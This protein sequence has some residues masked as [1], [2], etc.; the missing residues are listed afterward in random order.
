MIGRP[1]SAE[2]LTFSFD[3]V[4]PYAWLASREVQAAADRCGVPLVW[5]PVLLGGL[6][7][8]IGTPDQPATTWSDA[9]RRQDGLDLFRRAEL[10]G[11]ALQ[12]HPQHPRRSVSAMRL[13]VAA[14]DPVRPALAKDLFET[15]WVRNRDI[16]DRA[17]LAPVARAHGLDLAVIDQ[18][19][20]KA[21]LW[22]TTAQA[23]AEGAFG[24]PTYTWQGRIWW[25][26][27]RL[28]LVE[29]ALGHARA[30]AAP[31]RRGRPTLRWFHDFASPFSYLASTQIARLA[32]EHGAE[33][34]RVPLLLGGLFRDIGT[35]DVP[36]FSFSEARQAW[37]RQDLDDWAAWW[38][39]PFR[40]PSTFPLRTVAP[41]RAA[42]AHPEL[43]DAL[44]RAAWVD[45]RN[46]GDPRVVAQVVEEHG[47]D[48]SRVA[49]RCQDPAL[50]SRLKDHTTQAAAL[51]VCGVPSFHVSDG[52][53]GVLFWGQDR[54]DHVAR[55]LAGWRPHIDAQDAE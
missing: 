28:P 18:P 40:F 25:G 3:V 42:L 21:A 43:T 39:V 38:G 30:R 23:L 53:A 9:R 49:A 19:E 22:Q 14:P 37:T 46:I 13:L 16:A 47:L 11:V 6:Y 35:A 31:P 2:P 55:A 7:K 34:E 44:Y 45:D 29:Q 5:R 15:Y 32:R 41:L 52:D 48:P 36:L 12:F 26:G 27:D 24:V 20:T 1:M 4:C 8:A 17:V 10:A 50:K 51:G 54:L 33:L